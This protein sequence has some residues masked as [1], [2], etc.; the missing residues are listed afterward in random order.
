[1]MKRE[2][3]DAGRPVVLNHTA[4]RR[5]GSLMAHISFRKIVLVA[6]IVGLLPVAAGGCGESLQSAETTIA[7]EER[8]ATAAE[9]NEHSVSSTAQAAG[10]ETA[11]STGTTA[12]ASSSA[13]GKSV[14]QW[15]S[16]P[17][18]AGSSELDA[19]HTAKA[20]YARFRT[21]KTTSEVL[22]YYKQHVESSGWSVGHEGAGGG[23]WGR[24]G[25]S[26]GTL[27]ASRGKTRF[28]LQAGGQKAGTTYFEVCMGAGTEADRDCRSAA[29]TSG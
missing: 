25:G 6:L 12:T 27:V 16:V 9:A 23:G 20:S 4:V 18:P 28:V 26:D 15:H 14:A 13:T 21:D 11:S 22:A 3:L 17:P 8:A 29:D 5:E 2:R 19:S 1:M 10:T 24:Y 7:E